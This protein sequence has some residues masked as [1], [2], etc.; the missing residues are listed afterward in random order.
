MT[1]WN[2]TQEANYNPPV[3]LQTAAP[4]VARSRPFTADKNQASRARTSKLKTRTTT[5]LKSLD[6]NYVQRHA[7][8]TSQHDTG[9][10]YG[11]LQSDWISAM[12]LQI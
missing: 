4:T 10:Q 6:E 2:L 11:P 3:H 8:L 1:G 7:E 12:K 5:I 9:H